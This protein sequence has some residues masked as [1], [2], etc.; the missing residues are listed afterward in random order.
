MIRNHARNI[1]IFYS[2]GVGFATQT[3]CHLLRS[4]LTDIRKMPVLLGTSKQKNIQLPL[5][6]W[7]SGPP[8]QRVA[9]RV[10]CPT[11]L[12][13]LFLGNPL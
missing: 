9:P 6:G 12:D 10:A 3:S 5:V 7:A 11:R 4:I 8:S 1:Q 13:N 2:D